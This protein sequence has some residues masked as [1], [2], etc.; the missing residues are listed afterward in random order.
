MRRARFASLGLALLL[1]ACAGHSGGP[2]SGASAS[3]NPELASSDEIRDA[4]AQ[5]VSNAYDFVMQRHFTWTRA[6]ATSATNQSGGPSVW[7]DG[8]RVGT[9][10]YLRQI[11][12]SSV[13]SMR[14]LSATQAQGELGLN[15]TSGAIV[16]S[17]H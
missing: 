4:Q 13:T 8:T 2:E 11:P 1:G 17:T 9:L 7:L 12:L 5:G 10:T 14:H 15:N 3:R 6:V 16:V